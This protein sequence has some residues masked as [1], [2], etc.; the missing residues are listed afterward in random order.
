VYYIDWADPYFPRI[1]ENPV[2]DSLS[3]VVSVL[4]HHHLEVIKSHC[5]AIERIID[6]VSS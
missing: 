6:D 4:M 3:A 5:R 1:R 2:G